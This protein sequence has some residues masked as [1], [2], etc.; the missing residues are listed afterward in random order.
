MVANETDGEKK[1]TTLEC[2][3]QCLTNSDDNTPQSNSC[4]ASYNPSPK[5][6]KLEEIDMLD[7]A[8]KVGMRS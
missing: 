8:E 5:L 7:T 1:T 2:C 4:T 6:S 3:K